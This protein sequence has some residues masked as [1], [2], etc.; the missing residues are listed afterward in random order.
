MKV[1]I[2]I[3][4]GPA[5]GPA[6]FAAAVD[7]L[8]ANGIDSLWLPEMVFGSLVEPLVGMAYAL[9]RTSR[10]KVGTGIYVLPGRQPVL[11]AKQIASL[12]ALAPGRVLPVF[13]LKPARP[14]EVPLFHP[15]GQRAAVFDESLEL[16][17]LLLRQ[18]KVTFS[19]EFFSVSEATIGQPPGK[20]IDIWLGGSA[21]AALRRVGRFGDGWLASFMTPAQA[22]AG[23]G[24]IE[25]AAAQAGR[26]V[27]PDHFGISLAVGPGGIPP[28]LAETIR[29][30]RPGVDPAGLAAGSWA[31]A[32]RLIEEYVGAGLSKFVIRPAGTDDF[33]RFID[34]FATELMPLQKVLSSIGSFGSFP[35]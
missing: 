13:G 19:G 31:D 35:N 33:G 29:A 27:E 21:P 12:A 5:G 3:S 2:G 22:R 20:P 34:G 26:E 16:L 24:E 6:E 14:D 1:R 23:R 7:R 32:R 8:E 28:D 25:A 30:R 11:V 10:L 9:S 18:E 4:L 15:R 17:R